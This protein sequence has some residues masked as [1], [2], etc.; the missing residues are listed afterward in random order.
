MET[1]PSRRRVRREQ[2]SAARRAKALALRQAGATYAAI[3]AEL[4]VCVEQ[5]RGIVLK[6]ERLT[7]HRHWS[8]ALPTRATTFLR[9][10]SL[11]EL[12][13]AEAA[14]AV[15]KFTRKQ[16]KA[17]PNL[18]KGAIGAIKAWLAGYGLTLRDE[19]TVETN[20]KG[21]PVQGRPHDSRNP[22]Q[23]GRKASSQCDMPRNAP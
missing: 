6:A 13:E 15:A 14:L 8:D 9:L 22:S 4:G 18:G 20:K 2:Q 5:A 23:A 7:E 3:A 11:S 12:P 21:V 10:R 19:I 17:E 1:T 16:I